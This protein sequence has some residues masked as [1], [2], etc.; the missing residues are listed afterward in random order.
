MWT[1]K[2]EKTCIIGCVWAKNNF[3]L[4]LSRKQVIDVKVGYV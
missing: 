2:D 3:H 1:K 4:H